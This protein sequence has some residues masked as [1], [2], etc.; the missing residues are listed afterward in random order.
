MIS[1]D[2]FI[3]KWKGKKADWDGAYAGQCVDLFRYYC[4]EVLGIKQPAGVW[5]A[6]NFWTD[7]D[8]D[9]VLSSNFTKVPNRPDLV[10]KKGWVAV[11]NFNAGGGYGHIA[12]CTGENT[13]TQYFKSF[14]Q[15]WSKISYCE[16]V[17]HNYNN[18]YGFLVPKGNNM[19]DMYNGYDLSNRESMKVAVD[20]LVRVQKGEFVEKSKLDE[21]VKI[22]TAE[23]SSKISDY[24][25][26]I[27]LLTKEK[28]EQ[29]VQIKN[30]QESIT[31]LNNELENYQ[32]QVP[33]EE[34]LEKDYEATGRKI[35][36]KI[37]DTVVETSY[38]KKG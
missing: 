18:V 3:Q 4:D 10:P 13:G 19:S 16:I 17:N 1:L 7:F 34:D 29:A 31:S 35:I 37:G 26:K 12:I 27:E 9:P 2:E 22:K 23:L 6:V 11:W 30:L 15:N 38:K 20:I 14:D 21:L 5:G 28:Q 24:A 36:R 8:T 33:E 32:N 25:R